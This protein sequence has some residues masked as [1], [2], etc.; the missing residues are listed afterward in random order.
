MADDIGVIVTGDRRIAEKFE[1]SGYLR[2]FHDRLMQSIA[3]LTDELYGRIEAA[4][5]KRT[6]KLASE[7]VRKVT[8]SENRIVGK[9]SVSAE[10]AKAGALEYGGTGKPFRVRGHSMRLDHAWGRSLATP[11]IVDVP[12][13]S[14]TFDT[15]A[16]RFMR[17]PLD[18]MQSEIVDQL[19]SA[20]NEVSADG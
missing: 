20:V 16:R 5:P 4:V 11:V 9:V 2:E 6:G 3:T 10:F 17:G 12:D 14:R 19:R 18:A 8:D 7:I 13:H 1:N 15:P